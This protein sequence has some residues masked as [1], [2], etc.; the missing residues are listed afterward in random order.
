MTL[1][2]IVVYTDIELNDRFPA[3]NVNCSMSVPT[4]AWSTSRKVT[5]R[6]EYKYDNDK[7]IYE[8]NK[9]LPLLISNSKKSII[10]RRKFYEYRVVGKKKVAIRD[11]III[12][13]VLLMYF[14]GF[15][16][17]FKCHVFNSTALN[18]Q[19]SQ[20]FSHTPFP[21]QLG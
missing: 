5:K 18:I 19:M 17:E 20:I 4:F 2:S 13:N 16:Y 8:I 14:N 21:M 15:R 3:F 9:L 11:L 7:F 12:Y 1:Q 10:K 6:K